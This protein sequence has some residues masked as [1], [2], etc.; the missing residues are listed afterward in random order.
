MK[1]FT[2]LPSSALDTV[3][4]T[5]EVGSTDNGDV[6]VSFHTARG[7]GTAPVSMPVEQYGEFINALEF[8][9][10]NGV[11]ESSEE[12]SPAEMVHETI[13]VDPEG[14]I[15]FRVKGGRGSK[16]TRL[17]QGEFAA[18]VG[19]LSEASESVMASAESIRSQIAAGSEEV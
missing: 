13:S 19:L 9:V 7:R 16:P 8:Y 6:V 1:I 3:R 10:T 15:S 18:V 2:N 11:S 12:R 5:I 17:S 14:T 4:R